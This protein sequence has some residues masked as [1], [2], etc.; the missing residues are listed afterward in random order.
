MTTTN[1]HIYTNGLGHSYAFGSRD[2]SDPSETWTPDDEGT[3]LIAQSRV[4]G[5]WYP[6]TVTQKGAWE[7]TRNEIQR[8]IDEA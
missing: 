4:T 5:D 6:V 8:L 1:A 2:L 3:T 7:G